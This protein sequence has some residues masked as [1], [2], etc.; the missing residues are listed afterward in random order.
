MKTKKNENQQNLKKLF[1]NKETLAL[2]NKTQMNALLGGRNTI[3]DDT[4]SVGCGNGP[5]TTC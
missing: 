2:L 5:K 3:S 1:L 4:P